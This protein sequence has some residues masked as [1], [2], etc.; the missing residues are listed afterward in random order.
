[1][2]AG[3]VGT[4]YNPV[5]ASGGCRK[6]VRAGDTTRLNPNFDSIGITSLSKITRFDARQIRFVAR[7]ARVVLW[8]NLSIITH[9]EYRVGAESEP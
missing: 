1:M 8:I 3:A 6:A 5:I 7:I 4:H 2:E 9:V